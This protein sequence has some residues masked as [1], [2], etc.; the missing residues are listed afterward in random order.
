MAARA[1]DGTTPTA[2]DFARAIDF[3][4]MRTTRAR[5]EELGA[6]MREEDGLRTAVAA[7]ERLAAAGRELRTVGICPVNAHA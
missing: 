5:A 4:S 7:I 1:V 3:A 6:A 2:A